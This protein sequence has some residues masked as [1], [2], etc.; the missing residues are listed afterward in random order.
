MSF[1]IRKTIKSNHKIPQVPQVTHE[2]LS[3]IIKDNM[4]ILAHL[5]LEN[6]I[7]KVNIPILYLNLDR[8]TDRNS[9]IQSQIEFYKLENI[10]RIPGID[11]KQI[12]TIPNGI[13]DGI[14]YKNYSGTNSN[15]LGCLLSHIKAIKYAYDNNYTECLIIEDDCYF[16]LMARWSENN[17]KDMLSTLPN[18]WEIVS[19]YHNQPI[20]PNQQY[21]ITQNYN[22]G[23]VVYAINRKGMEKILNNTGHAII[24]FKNNKMFQADDYIY[25]LVKTYLINLSLFVPI[26]I[27]LTSVVG[28]GQLMHLQWAKNIIDKYLK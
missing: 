11:G 2:S 26:N 18:D 16:G 10:I 13:I 5:Y 1:A 17:I 6:P 7:N 22:F 12:K 28:N 4:K 3:V 14:E 8:S 15:E 24:D 19:L 27:T 25:D 23:T 20:E 21:R 9:F